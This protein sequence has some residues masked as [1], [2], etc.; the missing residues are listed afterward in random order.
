MTAQE[1]F[2]SNHQIEVVVGTEVVWADPH[3]DRVWFLAGSGAPR[4]ERGSEGLHAVFSRT[5][6]YRG[7]FTVV[8]GHET[9]DVYQ[10]TVTVREASK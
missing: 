1:L 5:G 8:S 2:K 10:L 6:T 7:S 3:F 9:F 4:V